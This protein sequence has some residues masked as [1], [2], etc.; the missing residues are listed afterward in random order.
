M[1]D[2]S[3]TGQYRVGWGNADRTYI[4]SQVISNWA[5]GD[6]D[7]MLHDAMKIADQSLQK[8]VGLVINMADTKIPPAQPLRPIMGYCNKW[9][10]KLAVVVLI[11]VPPVLAAFRPVIDTLFPHLK[12]Q[13]VMGQSVA[14]ADYIIGERLAS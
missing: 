7:N 2:R 8:Q 4:Y 13:I 14:D 6:F 3:S 1:K 12:N 9:P 11:D 10:D 5:W